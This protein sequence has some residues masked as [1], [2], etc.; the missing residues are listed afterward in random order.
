MVVEVRHNYLLAWH[1]T[2]GLEQVRQA[3]VRVGDK[4]ACQRAQRPGI[5][6]PKSAD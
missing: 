3:I 2:R 4:T 5:K 6:D 1:G